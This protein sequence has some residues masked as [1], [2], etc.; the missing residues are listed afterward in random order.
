MKETFEHIHHQEHTKSNSSKDTVS[1]ERSEPVNVQSGKHCLLPENSGKFG[2]SKRKSPQTEVGSSVG[3]HSQNEFNRF[4]GLMDHNFSKSMFFVVVIAAVSM[5][6]FGIFGMMMNSSVGLLREEVRLGKKQDRDRNE[7]TQQQNI[8]N[9][10]LSS[11]HGFINSSRVQR[12]V[13]ESGD[14]IGRLATVAGSTK[15]Q[16]TLVSSGFATITDIAPRCATVA[17]VV[18]LCPL[19]I[20]GRRAPGVTVGVDASG[21]K[22][23]GVP[24]NRPLVN[25]EEHHVDEHGCG[26]YNHGDEFIEKVQRFIEVNGVQTLEAGTSEHLNDTKDDRKLHLERVEEKQFVGGH[27]P[28]G[29]QSKWIDRFIRTVI[30]RLNSNVSFFHF[31]IVLAFELE[32]S[33]KE[34]DSEGETIIIHHTSVHGKETH[35]RDHVTTRVHSL[36]H[37]TELGI[38]VRLFVPQE[39]ASGKEEE[40][41][42]TNITVHNTKKKGKRGSCEEGGVCFSITR[43]TVSV[44]KLLVT[45]GELVCAKVSGRC[46]PRLGNVIDQTRHGQVHIAM[47]PFDG[48]TDGIERFRHNPSFSAEHTRDISLEHVEGV[49]YSL[50]AKDN[51]SPAFSVLGQQLAKA[52][53]SVLILQQNGSAIHEFLG[54]F[55]QHLVH[56]RGIVHVGERVAVGGEGVT[57]LLKLGF[58]GLGLVENDEN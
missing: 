35:H 20:I 8:L 33:A 37:F 25:D 23:P 19:A 38:V 22:H 27:V 4:N 43:D 55:R 7:G 49:V 14:E 39:V 31:A 50:F 51:P 15:V 28:D 47:G 29:V 17:I 30:G 24:V 48:L 41:T 1:N 45:V 34:V 57:N 12:N 53:T 6:F 46:W 9:S 10:A 2:V 44:D 16:W 40:Q 32:T 52:I 3:N 54:V 42:V 56:R 11:V 36:A 5:T 26:K 58:N 13:D 21:R 18:A